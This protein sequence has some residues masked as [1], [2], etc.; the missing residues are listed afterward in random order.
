MSKQREWNAEVQDHQD[1]LEW[2]LSRESEPWELMQ[3]KQLLAEAKIKAE[4]ILETQK[5]KQSLGVQDE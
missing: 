5:L 3:A 4:M 2:L 1:H